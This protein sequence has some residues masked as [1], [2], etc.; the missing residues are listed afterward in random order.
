[1]SFLKTKQLQA[2]CPLHAPTILP[3]LL[4]FCTNHL[5][6]VCT[7]AR[8]KLPC[9]QLVKRAALLSEKPPLNCGSH[10]HKIFLFFLLKLSF[11]SFC[12]FFF[13]FVWKFPSRFSNMEFATEANFL[14]CRSEVWFVLL[15]LSVLFGIQTPALHQQL[16]HS[17]TK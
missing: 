9:A 1:M 10:W 4:L 5:V 6:E 17:K 12:T 13:C 2:V 7:A 15:V 16:R 11:G 14:A 3:R 8:A